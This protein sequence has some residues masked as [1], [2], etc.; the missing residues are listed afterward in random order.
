MDSRLGTAHTA[1]PAETSESL[2]AWQSLNTP[3]DSTRKERQ[4]IFFMKH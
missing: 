4:I 1:G 2:A 3:L